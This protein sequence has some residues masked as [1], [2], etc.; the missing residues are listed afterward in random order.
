[1]TLLSKPYMHTHSQASC[2]TNEHVALN[3]SCTHKSVKGVYIILMCLPSKR[4]HCFFFFLT[5]LSWAFR[6]PSHKVAF[7]FTQRARIIVMKSFGVVGLFQLHTFTMFKG[8]GQDGAGQKNTNSTP[9]QNNKGEA[10]LCI[11]YVQHQASCSF[12]LY[13][14]LFTDDLQ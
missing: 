11:L 3:R 14:A 7:I 5:N 1:M 10:D 8:F 9:V 2:S 12:K 13:T 6:C 4:L